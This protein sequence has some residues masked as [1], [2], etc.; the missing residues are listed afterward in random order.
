MD[1]IS[2]VVSDYRVAG[3]MIW[4][5]GSICEDEEYVNRL[6]YICH[7]NVLFVD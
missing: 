1:F 7:N 2:H 4:D 3:T 5:S 6:V